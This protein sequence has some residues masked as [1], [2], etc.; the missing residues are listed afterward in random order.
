MKRSF[1]LFFTHFGLFCLCA[2]QAGVTGLPQSR[3]SSKPPPLPSS[4]PTSALLPIPIVPAEL[5][6][7]Y[8]TPTPKPSF[9]SQ[10]LASPIPYPTI[11]SSYSPQTPEIHEITG[12]IH[13]QNVPLHTEVKL[14]I[15]GG[16][17]AGYSFKT[18]TKDGKYSFVLPLM[19]DKRVEIKVEHHDLFLPFRDPFWPYA[20][21]REVKASQE[22]LDI[23]LFFKS[24]PS[25]C[26]AEEYEDPIKKTLVFGKMTDSNG[27]PLDHVRI[28]IWGVKNDHLNEEGKLYF[29]RTFSKGIFLAA[30]IPSLKVLVKAHWQDQ[31]RTKE[32]L[33]SEINGSISKNRVDFVFPSP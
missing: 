33:V 17:W 7:I 15:K 21:E 8:P 22:N 31:I 6:P 11:L 29:E 5:Y 19:E 27:H 23:F 1:G 3:A 2:C 26:P 16:I 25:C 9:P 20:T 24:I 30:R 14:T 12:I 4:T 13:N 32:L 18:R 28:Q 10:T